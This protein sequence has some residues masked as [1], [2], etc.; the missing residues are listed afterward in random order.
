MT[1]ED[2]LEERRSGARKPD[3]EYGIRRPAAEVSARGEEIGGEQ[4][5][6][7]ADEV[8]ILVRAVGVQF[9]TQRVAPCVVGK[10][11]LAGPLVLQHL[12]ERKL[13]MQTVLVR[14]IRAPEGRAHRARIF[15]AELKCLEI[16]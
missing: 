10:R 4:G 1:R 6:R 16:S 8:R 3:D 2:L 15:P 5:L 7:A 11:L 14:E 12:A 13:E 9:A